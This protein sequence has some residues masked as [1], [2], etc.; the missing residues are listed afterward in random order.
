MD[1]LSGI[2]TRVTP[3]NQP[4]R[5]D[6]VKNSAGGFVFQI[7][8][9]ERLK[10]FLILGADANTY[11]INA[12]DLTR[13]N[14]EVAIRMAMDEPEVLL[15]TIL[16][17]SLRGAAP[18]QNA[19]L[20]ALA[21]ACSFG[22]LEF[23]QKAL[24]ALPKIARTGTHLFIFARYIEQFR[25][26]GRSLRRAVGDWYMGKPADKLAY[27]AV[28]YRQ[29]EGWSHR[30]LLRL[31]HPRS[32]DPAMNA[33]FDWI[34]HNS[35]NDAT[36]ALITGFRAANAPDVS[37]VE[38]AKLI[39]AYGLS[40]EMLPDSALA[41]TK[42]WD[43]LLDRGMGMSALIRQLSRMT[44][45]GMFPQ[46]GGGRTNDV[47]AMIT[48]RERMIKD[49]M[50]PI[51]VLVAHLTYLSGKSNEGS[52]T[53]EPNRKIVDALDAAFYLAFEAVEPTGKRI[54]QGLDVSGSMGGPVPTGKTDRTGRPLYY[55]F[56]SRE[57]AAAMA[58]V[59][60]ATEPETAIFGFT[61]A[62]NSSFGGSLWGSRGSY[63]VSG[64]SDPSFLSPLNIS[65]RQRLSDIVRDV[66]GMPFGRT[67]CAL[68][69][70]YA[71]KHKIPVDTFVIYTDNETYA[72][73]IHPHQAMR[74]YRETM[75][76]N[77]KLVVSAVSSTGFSIAD[78]NDPGMLDVVGFDT[79]VPSLI[80]QFSQ[81][82]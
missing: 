61:G 8:D 58:M 70:V 74:Q 23:R 35:I 31:S 49:R 59:T 75:G 63:N 29:R 53:W 26:W 30:D 10:R 65:P 17:V 14:A 68:P 40:W 45:L 47:V 37:D 38:I 76:I 39:T 34:T 64:E 41:S 72:G 20:F 60:M 55:P 66:T 42:V 44:R 56:T 79:A 1:I 62:N 69:M 50:H 36:P 82:L 52:S 57:I 19:T 18:K 80:S 24:S 6:Q 25:G 33:T 21:A 13:A 54:F 4:A 78:P 73:G 27:Q 51:N 28:K 67:D 5:P 46:I 9:A 12:A 77:A 22:E 32:V 43:A 7:S 81:G 11:Y 15:A 2:N 48:N 71:L 16:D 3:Q